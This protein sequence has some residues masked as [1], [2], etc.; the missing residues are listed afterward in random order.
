MISPI[1]TQRKDFFFHFAIY[2][3]CGVIKKEKPYIER[4]NF[5]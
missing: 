5:K 4:Q 1:K 3:F 2:Q